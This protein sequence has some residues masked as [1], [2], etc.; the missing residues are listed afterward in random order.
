MIERFKRFL[1]YKRKELEIRFTTWRKRRE[2]ARAYQ[3][4]QAQPVRLSKNKVALA[5]A[6]IIGV[7][8][9][10]GI[11]G[12]SAPPREMEL[13]QQP[14]STAVLRLKEVMEKEIASRARTVQKEEARRKADKTSTVSNTEP[15]S[16]TAETPLI[17][18]ITD[19]VVANAKNAY[20]FADSSHYCILANK[21][22]KTM[23]VLEQSRVGW[24]RAKSMP[25]AYGERN[26]P[27]ERDGD[28]R[29]PEG[30][31][32]I[33]GRKENSE[34]HQ[35]YGPMAYVLNYPNSED[36]KAGRTGKGIWI[37]GTWPDS[38]P[39]KTRGCL[40][41][42]N[43][44][45][46]ELGRLIGFGIGTPVVIV[47]DRALDDP[48]AALD[49]EQIGKQ[50]QRLMQAYAHN[51]NYFASLLDRWQ[52]AWEAEN[53]EQYASFYSRQL[54]QGQ[55]LDWEGWEA[56]KLRT[57]RLYDTIQVHVDKIL[58][59]DFTESTATVKFVQQYRS[60]LLNVVNGK[61]LS[62]I[63][64]PRGWKISSEST[65]PQEELL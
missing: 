65:F 10:F 32:F 61:K 59:S 28:L 21:A 49:F 3:S 17:E 20:A 11:Y 37:H 1:V 44:H 53:I 5:G 34:L 46:L 27:K 40:E 8:M 54:F 47:D 7:A 22:D 43:E 33:V 58:L 55:G 51:Q 23:Y 56:R 24:R 45:L 35:Q 60:D 52:Q 4:D 26:G 57:F 50:R 29:T 16:D 30:R 15:Q 38:M 25:M 48:V 2:I 62:F 12:L 9:I 13:S 31:Y 41:I 39:Y 36:R 19:S 64:S 42:S 6:S 63:K 14:E 18:L